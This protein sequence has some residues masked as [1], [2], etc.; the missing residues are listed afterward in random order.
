VDVDGYGT[1]FPFTN[2]THYVKTDINLY[3]RNEQQYNNKQDGLN[4]FNFDC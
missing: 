1:K 4:G 2:G 3:L